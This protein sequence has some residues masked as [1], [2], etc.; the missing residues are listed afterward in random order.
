MSLPSP[1]SGEVA[2]SYGD[3]GGA[4]RGRCSLQL[5]GNSSGAHP[6]R[7]GLPRHLPRDGGG[8]SSYAIA[9]LHFASLREA[10]VGMTDSIA[11]NHAAVVG[12][13]DQLDVLVVH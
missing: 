5:A 7:R 12:G 1:V 6:L 9:L 8:E 11:L 10:P 2:P 13:R 3:G 4:R